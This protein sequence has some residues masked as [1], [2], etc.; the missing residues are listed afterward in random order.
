[1]TSIYLTTIA[2]KF[3]SKSARTKKLKIKKVE[4]SLIFVSCH[5]S[6]IKHIIDQNGGR[7]CLT[8]IIA[9]S[10]RVKLAT[11]NTMPLSLVKN[12]ILRDS[13]YYEISFSNFLCLS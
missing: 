2:P 1:M 9:L 7:T 4:N 13:T 3:K 5:P 12:Q 6:N 8:H 10:H 11:R